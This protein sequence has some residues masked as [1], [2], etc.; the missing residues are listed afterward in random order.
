MEQ[1]DKLIKKDQNQVLIFACKAHVPFGFASHAWFVIN[2]KGNLS[3]WEVRHYRNKKNPEWGHV[4]LNELPPFA[5]IGTFYVLKG[6]PRR[7]EF[8]GS[9]D[10][11]EIAEKMIECI[12]N[13]PNSYPYK[14]RYF[15]TGPNSN[16]YIQWVLSKFKEAG[17]P[18]AGK[19]IGKGY[20]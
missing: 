4:F 15:P 8:I 13:S 9:A 12:E 11:S 2:K 10:D 5:G 18:L 19:F 16:T 7:V 1:I 20:K 6:F 14:E 3:R 17:I